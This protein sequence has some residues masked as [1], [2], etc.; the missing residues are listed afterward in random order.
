MKRYKY[1]ALVHLLPGDGDV[2]AAS[3]VL[4][5]GTCRM[6]IKAEHRDTHVSKMFS[7]LV[8]RD[9]TLG[10]VPEALRGARDAAV[11]VTFVVL[12][13]DASDYLGTGE[14]F[15]LWAGRDL[16]TGVITRRVFV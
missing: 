15:A 1:Q 6:V 13:D 8:T 3:T 4:P 7:S 9:D 14:S 12:G 11:S 5:A 10:L 2:T 16:G